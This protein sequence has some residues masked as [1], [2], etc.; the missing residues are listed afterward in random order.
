[1]IDS[2]CAKHRVSRPLEVRREVVLL[3]QKTEWWLR[4]GTSVRRA[5]PCVSFECLVLDVSVCS[6]KNRPVFGKG[7]W[8]W[9]YPQPNRVLN[10]CEHVPDKRTCLGWTTVVDASTWKLMQK[11][12]SPGVLHFVTGHLSGWSQAKQHVLSY[13]LGTPTRVYPRFALGHISGWLW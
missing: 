11:N 6:L 10:I 9:A 2:L 7:G 13:W 8:L 12:S 1:M 4:L 3:D 5:C